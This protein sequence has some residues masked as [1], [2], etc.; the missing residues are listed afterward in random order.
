MAEWAAM[1]LPAAAVPASRA[2]RWIQASRRI[3][4]GVLIG[5]LGVLSHAGVPRSLPQERGTAAGRDSAQPPRG[6]FL[7]PHPAR[8]VGADA[9]PLHLGGNQY[10]RH[11]H[12]LELA[13]TET[14]RV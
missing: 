8:S 4:L 3:W 13:R 6:V 12:S 2:A 9:Q 10:D 11:L 1:S 7:L 5:A 14:G